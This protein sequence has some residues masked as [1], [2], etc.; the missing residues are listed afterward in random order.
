M[1]K[2]FK[3]NLQ[4]LFILI[5]LLTL[6]SCGSGSES[7]PSAEPSPFQ[8]YV[9]QTPQTKSD[10]WQALSAID[11]G[12][13]PALLESLID[14]INQNQFGFRRMDGVLI[15]KDGNLIFESLLRTSLDESDEWASN[16][17]LQIH[18]VHSVTKSITS[19]AIGIAIEQGLIE[20]VDDLA[21]NYFPEFSPLLN[22]SANKQSMTIENWLTMQHGL[23][24]NEWDVNYLD[25]SNQNKQMIDSSDPIRF[26]LD[27]PSVNEP[28]THFAYSTGISYA[29]GE[30]ISKT[31][32][33]RFYDFVINNIFQPLEI[34]QYDAWLMKNDLHAGSS[35]Y[36]T[37]RGMAKF[38]QLYLNGGLWKGQQVVPEYWTELSTQQHVS[39]G[40]IRYGY[41]WWM[42][43]FTV[44]GEVVQGY[45][46][47]GWGG[48]LIYVLPTLN[49]VVVLTGHRY[50]DGQS[51]E[52]SVSTIMQQHILPF[53]AQ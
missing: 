14:K 11:L 21:L 31:S 53:L 33:Q 3:F 45:S 27:L 49:S 24:W 48:Q 1:V 26:L 5:T 41:Q 13:D 51:D 30:I 47:N 20:S 23:Q 44:N 46:A 4:G 34:T 19:A 43:S 50:K 9:Y 36:L 25:N 16:T 6:V 28:G 35:L 15:V 37:M 2:E 38:G 10:G 32:G 29:L 52:T 18:A 7:Q 42:N 22:P 17:N 40:N 12:L 39:Q 8:P